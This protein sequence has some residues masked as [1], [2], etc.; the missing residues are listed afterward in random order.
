MDVRSDAEYKMICDRLLVDLIWDRCDQPEKIRS[1]LEEKGIHPYFS[2]PT[3]ALF[4]IAESFQD[5][6][7][8][9]SALKELR[10]TIEQQVSHNCVVFMDDAGH[11]SVLFSWDEREM[12]RNIHHS[13][14]E[15]FSQPV[16][17]G[18]GNPC[19]HLSDLY[20]SYLQAMVSLQHKF[21]RG[22]DQVILF[23]SVDSF[24]STVEYPED[25]EDE[26]FQLLNDPTTKLV[27]QAIDAFYESLLRNGPLQ[28]NEISDATIR[29]LIGLELRTKTAAG[30]ACDLMKPDIMSVLRMQSL[31]EVKASILLYTQRIGNAIHSNSIDSMNRILIKKTLICMENE[32]DRATL[33][34]V[35]EKVF[36]TPAYLS[37]LFKTNMG[38]TFIEYLTDIRI[39]KAKK[40]LKQ[41]HLKNYEVAEKVGYHDSRYF[42]QI[43]KKKVGLSPSDFRES[44]PMPRF[45]IG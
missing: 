39:G 15:T 38:V 45:K 20:T 21:Y 16:T 44:L 18:I 23:N 7:T 19:Q 8:K 24:A 2:Y 30:H 9:R 43:F 35:A 34:Y 42:S 27:G 17:V 1:R 3:L 36:I 5:A 10:T 6:W 40:L 37:M 12:I 29:L 31:D 4:E 28:P 32:Y 13:L 14:F 11:I 33:H 26:L 25:K 22:I 41:T